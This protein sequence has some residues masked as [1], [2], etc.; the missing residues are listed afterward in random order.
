MPATTAERRA[1]A[2][3]EF[4]TATL[5]FR[6]GE[7]TCRGRLYRPERPSSPP[8]VVM[9]PTFAAEATFGYREPAAR[10]ARAGYAAFV[11]DHRGFGASDRS[12]D[13]ATPRNR[14]DPAEQV[15]DWHA[16][17]DRV[18]TLEGD[19]RRVALWGFGLGGGHVVRVAAERGRDVD[20]AVA[21]APILDGQAFARARPWGYLARA[22][23]AGARDRVV[24][25]LGWSRSIPVVGGRE[26]F[27]VLPG[28]AGDRYLDLVP[29]DSDWHN[30]TPA[31]SLL[32]LFRYRPILDADAVA[33]PTLLIAAAE[34]GLVPP[35]TV[36]TAAERIDGATFLR[37]PVAHFDPLGD[38]VETATAHQIAFLDEAL[39]ADT[40]RSR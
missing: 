27:G 28:A 15:T 20:A 37:L 1:P 18:R 22:L 40:E 6:S 19:R 32:S 29:P 5:S 24:S 34:D 3:F 7:R 10:F 30:E 39:D 8:V 13:E 38:A 35:A 36:A 26:E 9:G 14:V 25:P 4:A 23:A 2:T 11:F 12:V 16:A 31:R 21:V 17:V 33:C